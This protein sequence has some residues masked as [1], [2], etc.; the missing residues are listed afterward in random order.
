MLQILDHMPNQ[1][2]TMEPTYDC[3]L[4]AAQSTEGVP[5]SPQPT[6]EKSSATEGSSISSA[7]VET[8]RASTLRGRAR[9][10]EFVMHNKKLQEIVTYNRAVAK[11]STTHSEV[12]LRIVENEQHLRV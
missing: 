11:G 2:I 5:A 9:F 6:P 4:K 12:R 7:G 1:A 10:K 3:T 8:P